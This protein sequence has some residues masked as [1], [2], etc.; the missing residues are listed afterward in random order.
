MELL[1][2]ALVFVAIVG[3]A[4]G[5]WWYTADKRLVR[6]RLRAGDAPEI[7]DTGILRTAGAG[8]D[9]STEFKAFS[10]WETLSR[11]VQQSGQT[12][13]PR[14][15]VTM[16]AVLGLVAGLLGMMRTGSLLIGLACAAFAASGPI[17]FLV[18]KR[19]QRINKFQRQLPDALDMI[20]RAT[21]AGHALSAGL[22]LVADESP[23]PLGVEF[24]RVVDEV[25]LGN[26]I[27]DALEGLC[28][29]IPIRDVQ[30]LSTIIRIQRTSGGN[31]G[32]MLDRLAAVVRDRF[33]LLSQARAV[34]AQQK[35]SAILIGLSPIAFAVLF[36]LMNPR[37][38]DPLLASP[39]GP[40][41]IMVGIAFEITGFAVIWRISK[42][43]V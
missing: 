16:M 10:L 40:M 12:I 4:V 26:D 27:N 42:L 15:I 13:T 36:R 9:W 41:L 34:A 24:M 35:W 33:K 39:K 22:Q 23:E 11:L 1:T 29:R 6:A 30:F 28:R 3:F 31:L 17:I 43:K 21:R 2:A 20:T 8:D 38:F 5:C 37:Y 25:R 18:M 14:S 32:E 7:A 19:G